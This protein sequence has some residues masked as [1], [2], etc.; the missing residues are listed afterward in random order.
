MAH[1]WLSNFGTMGVGDLV[2]G[3]EGDEEEKERQEGRGGEGKAKWE[4]GRV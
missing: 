3:E 4:E 2:R 1:G